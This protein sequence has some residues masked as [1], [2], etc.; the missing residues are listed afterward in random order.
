[1]SSSNVINGKEY[2]DDSGFVD[3]VL[4]SA[5]KIRGICKKHVL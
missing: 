3:L 5:D 2:S 1:M 4:N